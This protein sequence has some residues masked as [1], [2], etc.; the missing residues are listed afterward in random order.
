LTGVPRRT[1]TLSGD[2]EILGALVRSDGAD[3]STAK[4]AAKK[5]DEPPTLRNPRLDLRIRARDGAVTVQLPHA[6]DIHV[7]LDARARGTL[8]RP[9][10][11]AEARPAGV[12]STILMALQRLLR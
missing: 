6:P 8:S 4:A 11:T 12:Y 5:V 9:I 2:V 10:V 3:G 7:D 1:L